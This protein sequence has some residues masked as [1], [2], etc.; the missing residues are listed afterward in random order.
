MSST[1]M[2][3]VSDFCIAADVG[4][5]RSAIFRLN[6]IAGDSIS[7]ALVP[8][9]RG[10]VAGGGT[11]GRQTDAAINFVSSDFV[12]T[13]VSG[14]LKGS[15]VNKRLNTGLTP[16]DL[17]G[18]LNIHLSGSATALETGTTVSAGVAQKSLFVGSFFSGPSS[19]AMLFVRDDSGTGRHAY[20]GNYNQVSKASTTVEPHMLFTRTSST[21]AQLYSAGAF[22][23]QSTAAALSISSQTQF[24]AFAMNG[25]GRMYSIG[26]GMSAVQ[27]AAFSR[28]VIAL[29]A[30]IGR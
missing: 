3:A 28:A 22:V 4:L 26:L 9:F 20:S 27:I 10:P 21:L 13:G 16:N 1:T 23:S 17:G 25:I 5:F 2:A 11:F 30:A 8:L 12:E 7:S 15:F 18:F 29:N 24:Q 6:P 19:A 14:G